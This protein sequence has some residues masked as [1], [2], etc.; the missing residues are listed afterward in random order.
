MDQI[1]GKRRIRVKLRNAVGAYRSNTQKPF[2]VLGS[3]TG[4]PYDANEQET[5]EQDADD[6]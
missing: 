4:T 5:P 3:Y 6:L 1:N 2:D